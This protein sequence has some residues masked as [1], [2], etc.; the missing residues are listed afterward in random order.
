MMGIV[1]PPMPGMEDRLPAR[2]YHQKWNAMFPL[3]GSFASTASDIHEGKE[4]RS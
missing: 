1:K 2:Q 4:K 3:R